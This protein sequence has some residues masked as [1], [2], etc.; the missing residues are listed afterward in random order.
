MLALVLQGEIR[1][2]ICVRT[3]VRWVLCNPTGQ[4]WI[5]VV[6]DVICSDRGG[7]A[8]DSIIR[9]LAH[10]LPTTNI[11]PMCSTAELGSKFHIGLLKAAYLYNMVRVCATDFYNGLQMTSIQRKLLWFE[12]Y[13]KGPC[14]QQIFVY[15]VT[16][17]R[18]P[19]KIKSAPNA[20]KPVPW[21]PCTKY[22]DCQ[23]LQP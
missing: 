21:R 3:L 20:Q 12:T 7:E 8:G 13:I 10:K 19:S 17:L 23:I 1:A 5:H 2:D 16:C 6:N 18:Y 14:T 9:G 4:F 15:T 11:S 22:H